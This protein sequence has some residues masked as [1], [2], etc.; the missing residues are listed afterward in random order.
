MRGLP[1]GVPELMAATTRDSALCFTVV[2]I[3]LDGFKRVNDTLG[4]TTGDRILVAVADRLR[5]AC[6]GDA[7]M[8]RAGAITRRRDDDGPAPFLLSPVSGVRGR[9]RRPRRDT[10]GMC[11]TNL[12]QTVQVPRSPIVAIVA[13]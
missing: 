6:R 4:R 10:A 12:G 5:E 1:I 11:I 13:W 2:M 8:A 3:D 7:V 9:D